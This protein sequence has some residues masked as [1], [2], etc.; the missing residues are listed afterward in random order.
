MNQIEPKNLLDK[1]NLFNSSTTSLSSDVIKSEKELIMITIL[2]DKVYHLYKIHI[3]ESILLNNGREKLRNTI[4]TNE[5]VPVEK[6]FEAAVSIIS[7]Y[8]KWLTNFAKELP[9]FNNLKSNDLMKMISN[10]FI[11]KVYLQLSEFYRGE[12]SYII[13]PNNVFL[14]R[15]RM[16]TAFGEFTTTASF[17]VVAKLGQLKLTEK[18]TS[19]Y[20]PFAL[21]CCN[22]IFSYIL[23]FL[24]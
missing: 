18:E 14:S 9:G 3:K 20:Y 16:N 11:L 1:R 4:F 10:A 12:E 2:R 8:S 15:A 17:L 7:C 24:F 19:L 21:C 23:N 22:C 13:S 5:N 6:L